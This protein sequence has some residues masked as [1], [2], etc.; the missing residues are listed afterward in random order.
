MSAKPEDI[1][2]ERLVEAR[3]YRC[4]N[5][6]MKALA[7]LNEAIVEV[8]RHGYAEIPVSDASFVPVCH[9]L[10]VHGCKIVRRSGETCRVV[11]V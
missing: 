9:Y 1:L 3:A 8:S 5:D 7:A 2:R 4:Q 6:F 11:R 10:F